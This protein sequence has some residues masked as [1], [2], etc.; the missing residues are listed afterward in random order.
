MKVLNPIYGKSCAVGSDHPLL[1]GTQRQPDPPSTELQK[2]AGDMSLV[3]A[4]EESWVSITKL[5]KIFMTRADHAA[6]IIL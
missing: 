5:I 1:P 3:T 6:H 2:Q 4:R